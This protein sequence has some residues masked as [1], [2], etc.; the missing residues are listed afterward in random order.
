[1]PTYKAVATGNRYTVM[2]FKEKRHVQ[3]ANNPLSPQ[4][5]ARQK[6]IYCLLHDTT[7]FSLLSIFNL[8][9]YHL[10]EG[11]VCVCVCVYGTRLL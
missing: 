4:H 6:L 2:S 1:M 11:L 8:L 5:N 9:G 3:I 7:L 10:R